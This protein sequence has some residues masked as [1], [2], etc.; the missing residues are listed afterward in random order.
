MVRDGLHLDA[1]IREA[2]CDPLP[3]GDGG[4]DHALE[5]AALGL[6]CGCGLLEQ[7][8][9]G[10][11]FHKRLTQSLLKL[12][13]CGVLTIRLRTLLLEGAAGFSVLAL[14]GGHPLTPVRLETLDLVLE[15][16]LL[17]VRQELLRLEVLDL[18]GQFSDLSFG[19]ASLRL[20]R[21]EIASESSPPFIGKQLLFL[22]VSDSL[23]EGRFVR[24]VL[25]VACFELPNLLLEPFALGRAVG[26]L[27]LELLHAIDESRVRQLRLNTFCL[28]LREKSG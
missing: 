28:T 9:E 1:L 16:G 6:V 10:V 18:L 3:A 4:F 7:R 19:L 8:L 14:D 22:E 20:E 25:R 2:L 17:E 21:F 27:C 5:L 24:E 13:S 12:A 11:T 15:A 26:S 23:G